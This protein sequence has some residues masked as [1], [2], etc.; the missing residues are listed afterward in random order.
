[1][2]AERYAP[3]ADGV[4][5]AP[6]DVLAVVESDPQ[7]RDRWLASPEGLA[8]L[9]AYEYNSPRWHG[10]FEGAEVVAY[11]TD[12]DAD[13]EAAVLALAEFVLKDS[14]WV[15]GL[16]ELQR[17]V[18]AGQPRRARSHVPPDAKPVVVA[19]GGFGR[20]GSI[21]GRAT[22]GAQAM[23]LDDSDDDDFASGH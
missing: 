1:M 8:Y 9:K 3:T 2:L 18:A 5:D 20:R 17:G 21:G 12:L 7:I 4:S 6:A 15:A 14:I 13:H 10:E 23:S 11:P 19:R 16:L 22:M